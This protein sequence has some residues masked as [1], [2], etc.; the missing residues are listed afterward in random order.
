MKCN[1]D[2]CWLCLSMIAVPELVVVDYKDLFCSTYISL[3]FAPPA[4]HYFSLCA[5]TWY[6]ETCYSIVSGLE[7]SFSSSNKP[8]EE[9]GMCC[10]F[11]FGA[12]CCLR[13]RWMVNRFWLSSCLGYC[14]MLCNYLISLDHFKSNSILIWYFQSSILFLKKNPDGQGV[15][16]LTMNRNVH[17]QQGTF[18]VIPN[19]CLPLFPVISPLSAIK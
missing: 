18:A 19:V 9:E 17:V 7:P 4:Y 10:C 16:V 8:V 5:I 15:K 6:R 2:V 1:C 13:I 3:E 11:L 14:C 12:I